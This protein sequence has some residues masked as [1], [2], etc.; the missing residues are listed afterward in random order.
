MSD[1]AKQIIINAGDIDPKSIKPRPQRRVSRIEISQDP[2][3]NRGEELSEIWWR[4][5]QWAVTSYGIECLDGCYHLEASRL[6]EHLTGENPYPWP[7]HMAT[8]GWVDVDEFATA[9]MV[10]ILLHGHGDPRHVAAI[11]ASFEGLPPVRESVGRWGGP[12]AK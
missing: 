9:W 12:A 10:A 11:R 3:R 8:K 6:L 2:V 1:D 7:R 4:G 5:K